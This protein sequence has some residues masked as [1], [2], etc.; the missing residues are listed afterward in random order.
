MSNQPAELRQNFFQAPN[1]VFNVWGSKLK[2]NGI[3][4]YLCLVC[5]ARD[6]QCYPSL[7][8]ISNVCG[9]GKST[10][11][12]TINNL[13]NLGLISIS[14]RKNSSGGQTSNLYILLPIDFGPDT[15][16]IIEP[17]TPPSQI[18]HPPIIE[19]TTPPSQIDYPPWS[20]RLSNN[21][22]IEQD[23][24]NKTTNNNTANVHKDSVETPVKD[25]VELLFL[26]FTGYKTK[27]TDY[28]R[29]C[30]AKHLKGL[31]DTTQ[32]QSIVDYVMEQKANGNI[33]QFVPYVKSLVTSANKGEFSSPEPMESAKPIK[34]AEAIETSNIA[35]CTLCDENGV[36]RFQ[37]SKGN[38]SVSKHYCKHN[39]ATTEYI[40]GMT[41][42][43]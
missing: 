16:P 22:E 13:V 37:D 42:G 43:G 25:N 19:S 35:A 4:V 32:A 26:S 11:Q 3:A 41:K 10:V 31:K 5:H 34:S 8:R 30:F 36:L 39:V 23:Q 21:T 17:T 33:R 28:Q 38:V 14:T 6:N 12:R 20:N 15:S 24:I 18:D 2:S 9:M 27:V 1:A 7:N 40:E 29:T